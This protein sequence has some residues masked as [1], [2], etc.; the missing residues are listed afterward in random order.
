MKFTYFLVGLFFAAV[1]IAWMSDFPKCTNSEYLLERVRDHYD[2][3]EVWDT[4]TL[5]IHIQEPRVGNP[6]RH[7]KLTL[8]NDENYFEMERFREDG[9]VRRILTG[10]GESQIFLNGESDL[11]DSIVT[12]YRLYEDRSHNHKNFY[13]LMYGLP[14]SLNEDLWE[15]VKPAQLASFE[16]NNVYRIDAELKEDM[17]SKHWTIIVDADDYNLLALEFNHPEDPESEGEIL[18]FDGTI[19]ING[20]ALPRIRNWYV[21]GSEEYLGS[22][23]IVGVLE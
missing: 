21:Q 19:E 20:V 12:A 8:D 5:K 23:I 10:D 11:S 17:I 15:E 9:I 3:N 18:K 2:P 14:M 6:Q 16:G 4:T 7:T 22:D 13:Q 1:L